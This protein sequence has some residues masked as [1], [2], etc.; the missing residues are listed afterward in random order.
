VDRCG[1]IALSCQQIG[2]GKWILVN[3]GLFSC[4]V[5]ASDAQLFLSAFSSPLPRPGSR[6][7]VGPLQHPRKAK[8]NQRGTEKKCN[9]QRTPTQYLPI[10]GPGFPSRS[11]SMCDAAAD[12]SGSRCRA[13]IRRRRLGFFFRWGVRIIEGRQL[14]PQVDRWHPPTFP[15][16]HASPSSTV[17]ALLERMSSTRANAQ[18]RE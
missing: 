16:K 4:A 7:S 12:P 18:R 3:W 5:G 11:R 14:E 8:L 13:A 9:S 17:V 1:A 6:L 10:I 15:A 2:N